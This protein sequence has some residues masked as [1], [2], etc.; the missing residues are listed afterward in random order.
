M[1]RPLRIEFPD[2]PPASPERLAM[3]G[4]VVSCYEPYQA[5]TGG[6]SRL[7][8]FSRVYTLLLKKKNMSSK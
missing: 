3:A 1:T 6:L 8:G 5:W 2:A 7:G 4:R